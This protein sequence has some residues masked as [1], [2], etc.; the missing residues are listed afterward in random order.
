MDF[1][2]GKVD[3][4]RAVVNFRHAEGGAAS[5]LVHEN[6]K[7]FCER[8]YVNFFE[9]GTVEDR[10]RSGRPPVISEADAKEAGKLLMLGFWREVKVK[11]APGRTESRL[12]HYT[13]FAD[14]VH[15]CDRL[16][17]IMEKYQCSDRLMLAAIHRH[18][19]N[20]TR[21][22]L[23]SHHEFTTAELKA[24]QQYGTDMLDMITKEPNILYLI[25]FCDESTFLLHGRTKHEVKVYCDAKDVQGPDVCYISDLAINPI[26]VHFYLAVT[27]AQDFQPSGVVLYEECTGTTD[28]H[29]YVNKH[30]DGSTKVGNWEY[31]V[32][33]CGWWFR[34]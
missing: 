31:Q 29:R 34:V 9:T 33:C 2:T 8:H 3:Y 1:H 21:V 10:H 6:P 32:S 19:P 27:A 25:V 22:T 5:R 12:F 20:L 28:I 24:R 16:R 18:C 15:R 26:K 17:E 13:T 14:A 7:A 4:D 11:G 23:F 30:F